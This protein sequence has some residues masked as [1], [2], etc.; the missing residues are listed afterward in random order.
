MASAAAVLVCLFFILVMSTQEGMID[1]GEKPGLGKASEDALVWTRIGIG[2][3]NG[4]V[5]GPQL[6]LAQIHTEDQS[7]FL[8]RRQKL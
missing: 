4:V 5:W 7:H 1:F 6:T 2:G 3:I 8:K